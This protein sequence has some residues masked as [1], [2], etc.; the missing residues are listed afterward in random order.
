MRNFFILFTLFVLIATT[1][2]VF[3]TFSAVKKSTDQELGNYTTLLSTS[4]EAELNYYEILLRVLGNTLLENDVLNHPE[5]SRSKIE[6]LLSKDDRLAAFGVAQN[7]GQLILVSSLSPGVALPNILDN[8]QNISLFER[9]KS[10]N[11]L[12]VGHTYYMQALKQWVIPIR[13]PILNKDGTIAFIMTAGIKLDHKKH[14]W[15]FTNQNN[16]IAIALVDDNNY[17]IYSSTI[18]KDLRQ[19]RYSNPISK[20]LT[21]QVDIEA[22]RKEK[23]HFSMYGHTD[24]HLLLSSQY[25][26][27]HHILYVVFTRFELLYLK[28]FN[29]LKYFLLGIFLVY[30]AS[31]IFY[32]INNKKDKL[33]TKKLLWNVLHDTLTTLPNRTSLEHTMKIWN[34][35]NKVY[36]ALFLD[37]DNFKFINDNYGHPFGDKLI[38]VIAQRLS[39]LINEDEYLVRQGGD[40]FIII[41]P[42]PKHFI[43]EYATHISNIIEEIAHIDN[44][45]LH[46]KVSIGIAHYP[47]DAN[48]V[49]ALLSKADMALYEAKR[50]RCGYYTYSIA[51]EE[52]SK[53]RL[54]IELEL[55]NAIS[56][57]ELYVLLQPQVD[58][59]T[60]QI[61]GVEALV[62]WNSKR[63]GFIPP[64]QFISIAEEIGE[65]HQLGK[66]VLQEAIKMVL[67][68]YEKTGTKFTLSVNASVDELFH[69]DFIQGVIDITQELN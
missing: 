7:D 45:S 5:A 30:L 48:S 43:E 58:A 46:P 13:L 4:F 62:R 40:E 35:N 37:L 42:R 27:K 56:N 61:E 6:H 17:F 19:Q 28:T 1:I 23:K 26:K 47:S 67:D 65:I 52:A 22:M 25:S 3:Q 36:S 12:T 57:G 64:D 29:H 15:L 69:T 38:V 50:Q 8:P 33:Q 14:A 16:H 51:L 2:L 34:L 31:L 68:V 54:D 18:P 41:T 49:D 55:R 44:I 66:F 24:N 39:K 59:K 21:D 63:L 11:V 32:I 53:R 9:S 20:K 10:S 60:L